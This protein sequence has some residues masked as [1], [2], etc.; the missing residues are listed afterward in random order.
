MQVDHV[1]G[2][3][4]ALNVKMDLIR[5]KI[6]YLHGQGKLG[7]TPRKAGVVGS[8]EDRAT[9]V[10]KQLAG[11]YDAKT[12]IGKILQNIRDIID[13]VVNAAGV[14]TAGGVVRDVRS[15]KLYD[16][17]LTEEGNL[18][19]QYSMSKAPG[20]AD[21][22]AKENPQAEAVLNDLNPT[23]SV[24]SDYSPEARAKMRLGENITTLDKTTGKSPDDTV[25]I[26]RGAAAGQKEIVAGDF[27]TTNKQ[28]AKYYAGKGVVL[29]KR[30]KLSDILDDKTVPLG[31]EYI[32]RPKT[33]QAAGEK[34]KKAPPIEELLKK[35]DVPVT[36]LR[37]DELSGSNNIDVVR[38]AAE[39]HIQKM[40]GKPLRNDDT[41]WHLVIGRRDREKLVDSYDQD[42][43][44]LRALAGIKS[45]VKEAVL[46]ETH[47][48]LKGNPDVNAVH[49][50]YVPVI[51]GGKIYRTKLTVKEYK[52]GRNNLH[53][54]EAIEMEN[55]A[56]YPPIRPEKLRPEMVQ[57]AGFKVSIATL[58]KNA[59][60]NDGELF[61][62]T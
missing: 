16:N 6:R 5:K 8:A 9:W 58:F 25:T 53:S 14:R 60:K 41:G 29:E 36:V 51:I 44:G 45:L 54:L 61:F 19:N 46:A 15:G 32:Y 2:A 23:G 62:P 7:F 38:K 11:Q 59:R 49:R 47:G 10:G 37:G 4:Q 30:V 13:Q 42:I 56:A 3:G 55:P 27:I 33:N 34:V 18:V 22:T 20:K 50:M 52:A 26:Y 24:F 35:P 31:E 1:T 43:S 57:P 39:S 28:L 40:Q 12:P 17:N 21:I 48:D